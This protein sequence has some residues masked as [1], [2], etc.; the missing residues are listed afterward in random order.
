[1]THRIIALDLEGTLISSAAKPLPRPGLRKFLEFCKENFD[2]VVIMSAVPE[3]MFREVAG[4]F[5]IQRIVPAWFFNARYVNWKEPYKDLRNIGHPKLEEI[6][7]LD[8]NWTVVH[9]DQIDQYL[10][11][12][13]WLPPFDPDN[14]LEEVMN[15]IRARMSE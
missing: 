7:L 15:R 9:P 2:E 12:K 11:L 3:W 1:M 4:E 6:L 14:E 10:P 13:C 5:A 8:D